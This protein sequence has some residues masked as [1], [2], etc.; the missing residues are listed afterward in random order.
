MAGGI[1]LPVVTFPPPGGGVTPAPTLNQTASSPTESQMTV[2]AQ[3]APLRVLYGLSRIGAQVANV[4]PYGNNWVIQCVWGE[5]PINSIEAIHFGDK[6]VPAG[7]TQ[8]HYL[9]SPSQTVDATLVAAF[10][11]NSITY[12]DDLPDIAYSVFVVPPDTDGMMQ[13]AATIKGRIVRNPGSA[14]AWSDNPAL[15]MADFRESTVYGYGETVNDTWL[16][17]ERDACDELV[18]GVK[19][20]TFGLAIDTVQPIKN[21]SDTLSTYAGCWAVPE[22]NEVLLI[23]DRPR[24]T[25]A[26]FL[27]ANGQI[28]RIGNLKKRGVAQAPTAIEIRYTDTGKV[29]WR[30]E[31]VW[32]YAPGVLEGTTP[33]RDS[34]VAL[35][36]IQNASQAQRE[37]TERLNKLWLADLSFT[38]DVFDEGAKIQKGDVVEVT[39]PIGLDAKK[40]R[41]LD[42]T[43]DYGRYTLSL[44]E[45]DPAVYSDTV[46]ADP[47]YPDTN[48][49]SPAA[50]PQVTNA[51]AA[52]EVY[53]LATG[54]STSR[55]RL[56]WDR[57]VWPYPFRYAIEMYSAGVLIASGSAEAEDWASPPVQEDA[58]Y[59]LY[60]V[61]VAS[62]YASAAV[63][64]NNVT[65]LGK[66]LLPGDVPSATAFEAGGRVYGSCAPA[67]DI[68]IWRYEWRYW[69]VGGSW[70]TGTLIDRVD[71]LRIQT[72]QMPVGTWVLGVKAIDS[73]IRPGQTVGQYSANAATC[74]VTVTSDASSFLVDSYDQTAPTLTNMAAY[75][76]DRTDPNVYYQTEDGVALSTKM[77]AD[78]STYTADLA[79]YHASGTSTWLGESED[80]GLLLGG[81]WTGAATVE[82]IS[83]ALASSMGFS[84]NGSDWAYVAGLSAKVNARFA[85][86]KH[87]CLA[88]ATMRVTVPTQNIRL[89]AT[90]REE[91]GSGTSSA[92]AATTVFLTGD[93]VQT[94]KISISVL[95]TTAASHVEDNIGFNAPD[96]QNK[97]SEIV[98]TDDYILT[99]SSAT[100]WR[101]VRARHPLPAGKFYWETEVLV[102]PNYHLVGIANVALNTASYVGADAN[103]QSYSS[104]GNYFPPNAAYGAA[105]STGDIVSC[106]YDSVGGTIEWF[107]NNVSQGA[108]TAIAGPVYP[109]WSLHELTAG[110]SLRPRLRP[111]DLVYAPPSGYS[112]LPYA[113]D[114][115]IFNDAGALVARDF[116]F[117]FSGV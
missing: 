30:E 107:K 96:P 42:V 98:I 77:S 53:T 55:I 97:H 105:F 70:E 88:T 81:Q 93:F 111:S 104:W 108:K 106:A 58:T 20:R 85:R 45:Y 79:T 34:Q 95:G 110:V 74:P 113:F 101:S 69:P 44:V 67:V 64:S 19:R 29:P 9:G 72:D 117:A 48:L 47:S 62:V 82:A 73:V 8:T 68:D 3:N 116:M 115:R 36:G 22:G 33:R 11:S 65:A 2:A 32:A 39:H 83:G 50:P 114:E 15:C 6:D 86:L 78:L 91:V 25:D 10:A 35:P 84:A 1:I 92:T 71:A 112:P 51:V 7:V 56:T 60:I 109:A 100:T 12:A 61:T 40:M 66:G 99:I 24:A 4:V 46:I 89:N 52:E 87:E 5:G 103:G 27:H 76:L 80:F 38:L 23:P 59:S 31:S 16:T 17:A 26:S 14:A 102:G 28:L 18:S 57:P 43:G 75:T 21:W 54:I 41:V 94:R 63:Q 90:P 13:I 49:P 37:A